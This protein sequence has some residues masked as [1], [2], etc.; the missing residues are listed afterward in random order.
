MK[1]E[2]LIVAISIFSFTLGGCNH[3]KEKKFEELENA[4]A[5]TNTTVDERNVDWYKDQVDIRN[6]ILSLCFN[7]VS[8]KALEIGGTYQEEFNN[9]IYSKFADYPD[10]A[11]ARKAEIKTMNNHGNQIYEYQ[12]KG[13]ETEIL[14]P[15]NQEHINTVA[16]LV[17]KELES[18]KSKNENIDMEGKKAIEE[19]SKKDG[20]LETILK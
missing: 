1:F 20:K 9:D 17:A 19:I 8:Q 3:K 5:P 13:V 18:L 11:N 15:Q 4:L 12:I 14:T 7:H 10:C 6:N 2:I 16:S